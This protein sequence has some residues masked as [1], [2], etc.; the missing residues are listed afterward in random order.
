[1]ENTNTM[2]T[3]N[4]WEKAAIV[5]TLM[6]IDEELESKDMVLCILQDVDRKSETPLECYLHALFFHLDSFHHGQKR[7]KVSK[8]TMMKDPL[9]MN[10]C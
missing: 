8:C 4:K 10:Q 3:I 7:R 6:I 2:P 1:M 5:V 9:C